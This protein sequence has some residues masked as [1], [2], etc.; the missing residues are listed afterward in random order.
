MQWK[1]PKLV[2]LARGKAEERVLATCKNEGLSGPTNSN[3]GCLA[4]G[5]TANCDTQ[6]SS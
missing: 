5:C 6:V 1:A 4:A 3:N 2:I